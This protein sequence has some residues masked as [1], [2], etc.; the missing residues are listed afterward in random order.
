M[1]SASDRITTDGDSPQASAEIIVFPVRA[2]VGRV[3]MTAKQIAAMPDEDERADLFCAIYA[4]HRH[5]LEA[6][7]IQARAAIEQARTLAWALAT[8]LVRNGCHG[9]WDGYVRNRGS[10]R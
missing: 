3:R 5:Q 7:G 2:M 10:F 4:E 8:E 1:Q 9:G 6:I